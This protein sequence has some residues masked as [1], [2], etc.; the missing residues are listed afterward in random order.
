M[1][2]R[3][4][5][6]ACVAVCTIAGSVDAQEMITLPRED[7]L[8]AGTPS[9]VFALGKADG[10]DWEVFSAIQGVA[11]DAADNL[12]ILDGR[13]TRV[14][15]F[16]KTGRFVRQ[17]GRRGS[18]PG[19]FQAPVG[20]LV[21]SA[22]EV[23]ISDGAL[24][25]LVVYSTNGQYLRQIPMAGAADPPGSQLYSAPDGI[26]A[27]SRGSTTPEGRFARVLLISPTGAGSLAELV[28]EPMTPMV[29]VP[30]ASGGLRR[31]PMWSPVPFLAL[32]TGGQFVLSNDATY[33]LRFFDPSGRHVRT[34]TR[35]ITPVPVTRAMRDEYQSRTRV[36][37]TP[38]A[39]PSHG[40][41]QTPFAE[42]IAVVNAMRPDAS[43]RI[44]VWRRQNGGDRPHLP[45]PID[46]IDSRGSY[47]GTLRDQRL[48]DAFSRSGLLAY[49]EVD[50]L[51]VERVA[52][53][54]QPTTWR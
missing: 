45:G 16:D 22:S 49:I 13:N 32:T 11:F 54:R 18:G 21:T 25:T 27:L 50:R 19:E 43:G 53:R 1:T 10:E 4:L 26:V 48:P 5:V 40:Q 33:R 23:V 28:R 29:E 6:I 42:V 38:G 24:R 3:S 44:W 15:V 7:R 35:A 9:D 20:L 12:F 36:A 2:S 37:V 47:I 14:V 17:F 34:V 31:T 51:G 8:L 41:Y 39:P 30:G 46:I 52:V